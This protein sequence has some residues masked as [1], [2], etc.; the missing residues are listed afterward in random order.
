MPYELWIYVLLFATTGYAVS[1]TITSSPQLGVDTVCDNQDVTLMCH[2][3]QTT[4]NIITWYWSN[5]SQHGDTITVVARRTG[6]VY[7]CVVT[8]ED[9]QQLEKNITVLANGVPPFLV[10]NFPLYVYAYEKENLTFTTTIFGNMPLSSNDIKWVGFHRP[11]PSTAVVDNYTTD[12][13]L[14]SRLSLYELSFED[15]SGNYTNIVS[16]QCGTSSVSVFLEAHTAPDRCLKYGSLAPLLSGPADRT[17]VGGEVISLECLFRGSYDEMK[18]LPYSILFYWVVKFQSGGDPLIIQKN[19]TKSYRIAIYQTCLTT[20]F[21]CCE[22]V[23][24]LTIYDTSVDLDGAEVQCYEFLQSTS[25]ADEKTSAHSSLTV[26]KQPNVIKGPKNVRTSAGETVNLTCTIE[27]PTKPSVSIIVWLKDDFEVTQT[28]HY[29]ITT[30]ADPTTKYLLTTTLTISSVTSEDNGK[31]TCYCYYNRSMVTSSHYV[32]SNQKSASLHVK[33][34]SELSDQSKIAVIIATTVTILLVIVLWIIGTM[35][36]LVRCSK[37]RSQ[38]LVDLTRYSEDDEKRLLL[39]PHEETSKTDRVDD[40]SSEA[41]GGRRLKQLSTKESQ[42]QSLPH[43]VD[44]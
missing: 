10:A 4:G 40:K 3:D 13:I 36:C 35:I 16:N 7:I 24:K 17:T 9:G 31:Y 8:S 18:R 28:P 33:N 38:K 23:S 1:I 27:T 44:P 20:N 22:F 30:T 12:G 34:G 6:V 39:P 37:N 15:D 14:Y 5:Q 32:T 19:N 2:T 26:Y 42:L 25:D 21:S 41:T 29:T 43:V 11:L